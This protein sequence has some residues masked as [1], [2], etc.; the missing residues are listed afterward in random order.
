M[1]GHIRSGFVSLA[2]VISG[3]VRLGPASSGEDSS[4]RDR[5]G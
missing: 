4:R 5:S 3:Y 2:Q 1:L